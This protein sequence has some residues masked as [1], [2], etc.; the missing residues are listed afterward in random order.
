MKKVA[1]CLVLAL[2]MM[3]CDEVI[4]IPIPHPDSP[5]PEVIEKILPIDQDS[6]TFI[7][8][9]VNFILDYLNIERSSD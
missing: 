2:S 4:S 6:Y 5:P 3:A 7:A 9:T 1:L 8:Q